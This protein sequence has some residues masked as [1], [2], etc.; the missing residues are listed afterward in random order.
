M[1]AHTW[2]VLFGKTAIQGPFTEHS[3]WTFDSTLELQNNDSRVLNISTWQPF[4][5]PLNPFVVKHLRNKGTMD[6]PL[7]GFVF[8][9]I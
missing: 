5:F 1:F 9:H 6:L 3:T 2:A 7:N 4:L 8:Y